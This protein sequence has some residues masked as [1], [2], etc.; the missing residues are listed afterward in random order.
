MQSDIHT[1]QSEILGSNNN[2]GGSN[3]TAG[4]T[5]YG[6][7]YE[8]RYEGRYDESGGMT[9][10]YD[11]RERET[12]P[13]RHTDVKSEGVQQHQRFGQLEKRLEDTMDE[14]ARYQ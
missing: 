11:E 2:L 8:G 5:L 12:L 14:V 6:G 9:L 10:L 3:Y 1:M 13:T 7:G 4:D